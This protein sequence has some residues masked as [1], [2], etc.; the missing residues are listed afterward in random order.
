MKKMLF[1]F[2]AIMGLHTAFSQ[3]TV[4]EK[5]GELNREMEKRFREND[6]MGVAALYLD[7]ALISAGGR[8][9]VTGRTAIDRYWMGLKDQG[10]QWKLEIDLIEDFGNYVLQ[11]GRSYLKYRPQANGSQQESNVR[12]FIVWK[13][14]GDSYR[15]EK[16]IYTRL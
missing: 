10:A 14:T 6:M 1:L 15:I 7:S 12:F 4:Q 13:K 2:I 3:N 11:R 16:D 9:N 8:M 5:I